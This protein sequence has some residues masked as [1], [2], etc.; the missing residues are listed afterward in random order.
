MSEKHYLGILKG[1]IFASF[2]ILFFIFSSLLFPF[3]SSKQLS[4][5]ILIEVLLVICVLFLIKYPRYLPKKSYLSWGLI[6]YFITI[7]L[8]LVV[9]VDFNLSFW[10]D[11]ERMLGLFH[12][13]HFLVFYFIIITVFRSKKDFQQLLQVLIGSAVVVALYG[14]FKQTAESTIGNRAYVAAI[15]LFAMFLQALFLIQKKEWWL[16]LLYGIGIIITFISFVNPIT[17]TSF[18]STISLNHIKVFL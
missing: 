14:I 17:L 8:S 9:S 16:K 1:G 5:N 13:L 15:M 6:A 18:I 12:L 7:L 2:I 10:G 3:I 11:V 4:F